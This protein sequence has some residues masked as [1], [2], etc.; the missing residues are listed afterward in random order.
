MARRCDLE[1][2]I[3]QSRHSRRIVP[4]TRSTIE[5]ALGLA[6]GD[7]KI[8]TPNALIVVDQITMPSSIPDDSPQ[9]LEGPVRARIRCHIDMCQPPRT[10]LDHH[11]HIQHP[12]RRR[13]CDEEVAG[14]DRP[15][16]VL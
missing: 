12:E 13:D 15:G 2:G 14:N 1:S 5:F 4:I 6:M 9:L 11:E 7:R 3:I 10:V 16:V 8:S